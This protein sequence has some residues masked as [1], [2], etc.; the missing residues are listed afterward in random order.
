MNKKIYYNTR[1]LVEQNTKKK[2]K[3]K[4]GYKNKTYFKKKHF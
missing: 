2:K 1:C 4:L 3:Q